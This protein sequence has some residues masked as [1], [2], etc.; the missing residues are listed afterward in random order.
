M[1]ADSQ[2]RLLLPLDGQGLGR[3]KFGGLMT[4]KV[5]EEVCEMT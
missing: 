4:R 1:Y 3:S 2:Q 5:E